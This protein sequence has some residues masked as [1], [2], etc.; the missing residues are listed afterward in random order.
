MLVQVFF[1]GLSLF[2]GQ[3]YW[4]LHSTFGHALVSVETSGLARVGGL[5]HPGKSICGL[6]PRRSPPCCLLSRPG[7]GALCS[8][9]NHR[10][11]FANGGAG[12]GP[13]VLHFAAPPSPGRERICGSRLNQKRVQRLTVVDNSNCSP[14]HLTALSTHLMLAS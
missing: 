6:P 8:R 10:E 11:A 2:T 4:S 9:P 14:N 1:V 13:N 12:G 3:A 7:S 5:P